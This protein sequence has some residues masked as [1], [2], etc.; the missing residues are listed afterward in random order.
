MKSAGA[1]KQRQ[2]KGEKEGKPFMDNFKH[3]GEEYKYK[4]HG[5]L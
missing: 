1:E 3:R 2:N 4:K 5:Q